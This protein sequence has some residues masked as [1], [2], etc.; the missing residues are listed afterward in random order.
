MVQTSPIGTFAPSHDYNHFENE[1]NASGSGAMHGS[2]AMRDGSTSGRSFASRLSQNL[3]FIPTGRS[4]SYMWPN[5]QLDPAFQ[6][7]RG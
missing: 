5:M 7:V 6:L 2:G 1:Y 4:E 3:I